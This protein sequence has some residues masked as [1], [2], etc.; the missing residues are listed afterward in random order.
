MLTLARQQ[1]VLGYEMDP[2]YSIYIHFVQ[3]DLE[4]L[5]NTEEVEIEERFYSLMICYIFLG[6][7][8]KKLEFCELVLEKRFFCRPSIV[9]WR[10]LIF[11]ICTHWPGNRKKQ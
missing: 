6:D 7:P 8:K 9:K 11:W 2:F 1:D 10:S 4:W 3:G 5:L